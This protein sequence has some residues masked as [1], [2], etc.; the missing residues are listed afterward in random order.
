LLKKDVAVSSKQII[1]IVVALVAILGA[2]GF[3]TTN[4]ISNKMRF[5]PAKLFADAFDEPVNRAEGLVANKDDSGTYNFWM[6]F[7]YPHE[8]KLKHEEE[9]QQAMVEE[10]R[11]WFDAKY[12]GEKALQELNFLKLKRRTFNDATSVTNE[13]L[14]YNPHTDD[15]YY[16]LWGTNR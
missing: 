13:W 7:K 3:Y 12:P 11:P 9:F 2:M 1:L 6:H 10:A 8:A 14:L 16:R 15:H 4:V 5:E